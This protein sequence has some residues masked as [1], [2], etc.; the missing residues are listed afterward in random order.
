MEASPYD[1]MCIYFWRR[2]F[3]CDFR[4]EEKVWYQ[5]H[6]IMIDG[7]IA[8]PSEKEVMGDAAYTA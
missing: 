4:G 2:P 1:G 7:H 3:Q 8:V 6:P 5:Y